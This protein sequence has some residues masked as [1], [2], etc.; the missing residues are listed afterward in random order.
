MSLENTKAYKQN[1]RWFCSTAIVL[2][3]G[4]LMTAC[5]SSTSSSTPAASS[6]AP[7]ASPAPAATAPAAT[8]R[9]NGPT[10]TS[11]IHDGRTHD[12]ID[13][14]FWMDQ[15][16]T[17]SMTLGDRGTFK[18]DWD[19][20][21]MNNIL[22]RTGRKWFDTDKT[23]QA[24][25]D[26]KLDYA[27]TY[28]PE[29]SGISFLCVYGWFR[30]SPTDP[31][32]LVEYYIVDNWGPVNRPPGSWANA[33]HKGQLNV[34]GGTY[35]LY[36]SERVMQP[37]INGNRTFY[38]YWSVRTERRTGGMV[39]V[40]EHFNKWE[41]SQMPIAHLYEVALCVEGFN[42]SGTAEITKHEMTINGVNI[43]N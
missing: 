13:F 6:N 43:I 11:N 16:V 31:D 25:G 9:F 37:S 14:E 2:S 7:A 26:I 29:G 28:S 27:A 18:C 5:G 23:H 30:N 8:N 21:G 33:T 38:Q 41:A 34:D 19:T 12:G 22:F 3:I 24:I 15:N 20:N 36:V 4:I 39:F 1:A 40:S 17:G 10:I 42:S 35:D 32:P